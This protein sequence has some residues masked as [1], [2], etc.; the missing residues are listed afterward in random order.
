MR[1]LLAVPIVL[2]I[3][4]LMVVGIVFEIFAFGVSCGRELGEKLLTFVF[5]KGGAA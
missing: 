5:S 2:V 1:A 4:P 3:L